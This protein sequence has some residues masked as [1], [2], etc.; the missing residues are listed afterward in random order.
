M[1][2][3]E[4][5]IRH[6]LTLFFILIGLNPILFFSSVGYAQTGFDITKEATSTNNKNWEPPPNLNQLSRDELINSLK[7]SPFAF[8]EK[9]FGD[10]PNYLLK[11]LLSIE[12]NEL[13]PWAFPIKKTDEKLF[14]EV[15]TSANLLTLPET[16]DEVT[17]KKIYN[18]SLEQALEFGLQ[19]NRDIQLENIAVE[20]SRQ[21]LREERAELFPQISLISGI[22]H[23]D[24][25]T[26]EYE[27][28]YPFFPNTKNTRNYTETGGY[29]RFADATLE[30]SYSYPLLWGTLQP[31]LRQ[32]S[33]EADQSKLELEIEVRDVKE[34]IILG[35]YDIQ[36]QQARMVIRAQS[37]IRST[38]NFWDATAR[39]ES[40]KGKQLG[41][42]SAKVRM[43]QDQQ[44]LFN[45]I[46]DF[47][48]T[49]Y[50]FANLLELS[51]DAVVLPAAPLQQERQWN[52]SLEESILRAYKQRL[53]LDVL[54]LQQDKLQ[55]SLDE[56]YAEALPTISFKASG[57]TLI[58]F[59]SE[60]RFI[61]SD[62]GLSSRELRE[63]QTFKL[64]Y[65][66]SLFLEWS[67]QGGESAAIIEQAKL[68]LESNQLSFANQRDNIRD[69]VV[70]AYLN[71]VSNLKN[72]EV[73]RLEVD[74]A[75]QALN[76][77]QKDIKAG[78]INQNDL[79][80][81]EEDFT[82]AQ[83][84]LLG[85]IIGYNQALTRLKRVTGDINSQSNGIDKG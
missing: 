21:I 37:L 61:N 85:A 81:A 32:A 56:A 73:S 78:L 70:N 46:A 2:C 51:F 82:S 7:N 41:I 12:A 77:A 16:L 84:N 54:E 44:S 19:N 28:R 65:S 10:I 1:S 43:L 18:F 52:F 74:V 66:V 76:D 63:N 25:T 53:D 33:I 80:I 8:I 38:Q 58:N 30:I 14:N 75:R 50:K 26:Q 4:V 62:R 79:S 57:A 20:S 27:F 71:L 17:T 49:V 67:L 11:I 83:F 24:D 34:R 48:Q 31:Q 9:S 35:F 5:F 15:K 3:T 72:I 59:N 22:S 42:L 13:E 40:E 69:E 23:Q 60:D 39:V 68:E 45:A 29:K 36:E 55:A 6:L 47:Y 64:E